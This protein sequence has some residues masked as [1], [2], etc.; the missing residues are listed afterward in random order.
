MTTPKLPLATLAAMALVG[1]A[2]NASSRSAHPSPPDDPA[3]ASFEAVVVGT[4]HRAHLTESAYPLSQLAGL[5]ETYRPDLILVEIRP[6]PFALGHLE[7]GPFEMTY[8]TWLGHSKGI[9]V[10]PIDWFR[11]E[12][13][14]VDADPE[15]EPADRHAYEEETAALD[16]RMD[17]PLTFAEVHSPRQDAAVLSMLNVRA[18]YLAGN[19]GWNRRQAW[20]HQQ[21]LEAIRRRGAHR[22]LAFVGA[23]HRPELEAFLA[24]EGGSVRSPRS[25][26]FAATAR[27]PAPPQVVQLWREG[28]ARL[29]AQA[30]KAPAKRAEAL[31]S[32]ARYFEVAADRAGQCC[33]DPA[34]FD[35]PSS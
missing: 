32:K 8:V 16:A 28:A 30:A 24:A 14:G 11:D 23:F 19:P 3:T 17:R 27:T 25:I 12:D 5:I 1:C 10:S 4:I 22:V 33:V 26:P 6:E 35:A 13:L 29:R 34:A 21:A 9:A 7:D 2:T 18:R 31:T 20:L 15:P